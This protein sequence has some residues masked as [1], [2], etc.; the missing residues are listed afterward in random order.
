MGTAAVAVDWTA[1]FWFLALPVGLLLSPFVLVLVVA[2]LFRLAVLYIVI[3]ERV[4]G[5]VGS[6]GRG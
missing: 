2:G 4:L 5:W 1:F 3:G 6:W